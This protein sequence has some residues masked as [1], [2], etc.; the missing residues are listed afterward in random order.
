MYI[1]S[2][3][4]TEDFRTSIYNMIFAENVASFA[5]G[6]IYINLRDNIRTDVHLAKRFI[7]DLLNSTFIHNAANLEGTAMYITAPVD[8]KLFQ[9][10]LVSA[11]FLRNF[12]LVNNLQREYH[13]SVLYLSCVKDIM[14]VNSTFSDNNC[15][16]VAAKSSL[17][18]LHG[19]VG[20]Y[21]N[22]GYSGGALA[23]Y[24]DARCESKLTIRIENSMMLIPHTSVYIVNNTAVQYG[25]GI[26][27]DDVCREGGY[28]FFQTG[29]LNYTQ[30]DA[31]VIMEGNRAGKAGDSIFGG[32]LNLCYMYLETISLQHK[33]I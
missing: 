17:F 1:Y 28:C 20:F 8:P 3:L 5:G 29:N 31:R 25:G 15:T 13:C 19:T 11:I 7:I 10:T 22:T 18:Y 33:V 21:R 27:A 24:Y 9:I 30:M 4:T 12:M 6:A 14:I 2:D 16:S 26:L 23:F 32:C